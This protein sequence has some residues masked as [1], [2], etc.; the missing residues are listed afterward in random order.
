MRQRQFIALAALALGLALACGDTASAQG[1]KSDS[2]V[3][4]T[5]KADKAG[6]DGKQVVTVTLEVDPKYKLYANPV[7]NPDYSEAQTTVTISGKEKLASVKVDYPAGE[8]V[9]DKTVG[10][11]KVYKGKVTIKAVVQ[12]ARGD[13]GPLSVAVALQACSD[14]SCLLPATIK[15]NVP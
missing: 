14:K 10:D 8:T 15:V 12:R 13:T 4:A 7:G 11:Y 6:D 9:K 3:K 1:K 2:V 5:A